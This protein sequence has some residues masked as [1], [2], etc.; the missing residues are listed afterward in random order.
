MGILLPRPSSYALEYCHRDV[1][2]GMKEKDSQTSGVCAF[3]NDDEL[4]W[5][6][7]AVK[8]TI[9]ALSGAV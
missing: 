6:A 4:V 3:V 9:D 7:P 2:D 5:F 1:T 8:F